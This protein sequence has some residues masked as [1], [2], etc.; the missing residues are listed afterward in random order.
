MER[1]ASDILVVV[2]ETGCRTDMTR[3]HGRA[4]RSDR[5]T[6]ESVPRNRGCPTTVIGVLTLQG[7]TEHLEMEGGT[8]LEAWGRF[9]LE[10]LVPVLQPGQVVVWDSLAV[11]KCRALIEVI[12]SRGARVV[13]LPPYSP[14]F[15]PITPAWSKMKALLRK[16]RLRTRTGLRLGIKLALSTLSLRDAAGWFDHCGYLVAQPA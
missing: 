8:D 10:H 14:A 6:G 2:D 11:H 4:P 12:E 13:F 5:L 1:V 16:W 9:V 3:L 7:I 15:S